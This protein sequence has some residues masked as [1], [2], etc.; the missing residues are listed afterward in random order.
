MKDLRFVQSSIS[1]VE[2]SKKRR[3]AKNSGDS[4]P[5]ELAK[6]APEIEALGRKFFVMG[7]PWVDP[8]SFQLPCPTD[9]TANGAERF[10]TESCIQEGIIAEL[11][12]F[13]P[14]RLH[15]AMQDTSYFSEKVRILS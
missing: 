10:A 6:L 12:A 15:Q 13:V 4:V 5:A 11:Y 1:A 14:K 9:V 8:Q 2:G 7:E 3:G